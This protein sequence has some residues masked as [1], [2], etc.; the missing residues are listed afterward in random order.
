M[1]DPRRN[2]RAAKRNCSIGEE[3]P[4]NAGSDP[5]PPHERKCLGKRQNDKPKKRPVVDLFL[6]INILLIDKF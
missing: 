1:R 2:Y 6:Q 3:G 4:I 5:I